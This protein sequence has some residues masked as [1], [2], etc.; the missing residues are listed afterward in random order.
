M[1][2]MGGMGGGGGGAAAAGKR[3][4]T[5][6]VGK[7]ELLSRANLKLHV[8]LDPDQVKNIAEQL[9]ALDAAETMTAEEAQSHLESLEALLTP[10][11]K[12]TI[13]LIGLPGGGPGGQRGGGGPPGPGGAGPGGPGGPPG[14]PPMMG[15]MM[16]MGGGPPD[17]N[18]FAQETNQKRLRDLLTRLQPSSGGEAILGNE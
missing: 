17:A 2:G 7:L 18:P 13:S 12:E 9:A 8:E 11:Q 5:S 10:E 15:M 4:L 3:N 14:G 1:M 6:L 16:G